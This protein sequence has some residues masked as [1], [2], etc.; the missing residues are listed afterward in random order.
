MVLKGEKKKYEIYMV[1]MGKEKAIIREIIEEKLEKNPA[2][3]KVILGDFNARIGEENG[4]C[5]I[6]DS[7]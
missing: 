7:K 3:Y 4:A 2:V 5:I 6:G 1:Y